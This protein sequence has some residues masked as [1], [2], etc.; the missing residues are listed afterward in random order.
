MHQAQSVELVQETQGA[1]QLA[2]DVQ[3]SRDRH[4]SLVGRAPL[5]HLGQVVALD[6]LLGKIGLAFHFTDITDSHQPIMGQSPRQVGGTT[7]TGQK[8]DVVAPIGRWSP[9]HALALRA[10]RQEDPVA[11]PESL[12]E[13]VG[14]KERGD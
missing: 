1:A 9:D 11:W 6:A 4:P 12:D 7:K 13:A 5:Q 2:T 14:S 10:E 8:L 3:R